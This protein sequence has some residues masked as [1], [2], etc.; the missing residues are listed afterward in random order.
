[1]GVDVGA[2]VG[3]QRRYSSPQ[4]AIGSG[5]DSWEFAKKKTPALSAG[6]SSYGAGGW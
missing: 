4:S 6:A 5:Q 1:M 2:A 3:P